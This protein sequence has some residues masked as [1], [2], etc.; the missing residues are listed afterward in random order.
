[1]LSRTDDAAHKI[2]KLLTESSLVRVGQDIALHIVV[3]PPMP[4][5]EKQRKKFMS[6]SSH[7]IDINKLLV[8]ALLAVIA[9]VYMDSGFDA[10]KQVISHLGLF[11]SNTD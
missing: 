1:M 6:K 8:D 10:V 5:S 7:K 11:I 3:R 4:P 2:K 9:A